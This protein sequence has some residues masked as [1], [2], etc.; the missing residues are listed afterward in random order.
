MYLWSDAIV[1]AA[2]SRESWRRREEKRGEGRG[3]GHVGYFYFAFYYR[4]EA[5]ALWF[6][7]KA[8]ERCGEYAAVLSRYA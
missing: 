5:E 1:N 4:H 7:R 2:N 3:Q 6:D 8:S